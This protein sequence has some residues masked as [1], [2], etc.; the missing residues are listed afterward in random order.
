[1]GHIL[2]L[3]NSNKNWKE[4]G[5]VSKGILS[6]F[7]KNVK[8]D[9]GE[10]SEKIFVLNLPDNL[11]GAY[12]ARNG[13]Y[14]SLHLFEPQVF[15]RIIVGI[16]SH[17][18]KDE[19]DA[20]SVER[21]NE[22]TFTIDLNRE[23]IFFLQRPP[24][25][26]VFYEVFDFNQNVYSLKFSKFYGNFTIMSY[27][28]GKIKKIA[29]IKGEK[30]LPFGLIPP[31][32]LGSIRESEDINLSGVVVSDTEILKIEVKRDR[33]P[34]DLLSIVD[35]NGLVSLGEASFEMGK[36]ALLASLY[37]NDPFELSYTFKY[38]ISGNKLPD[39]ELTPL[40]IH[41]IVYD[42]N[43]EHTTIEAMEIRGQ[44]CRYYN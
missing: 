30:N 11:N 36:N 34:S 14:E 42:K 28:E 6:S 2:F 27:S 31:F 1:M 3:Y 19:R 23:D 29:S 12:I 20:V 33:V 22:T 21:V 26:R 4:A 5:S 44:H 41:V 43:G 16:S 10:N 39:D 40:R 24:D 25:S 15:K 35:E 17:S 7:V 13:F 8:E 38:L 37:P 32:E 18:L 9:P